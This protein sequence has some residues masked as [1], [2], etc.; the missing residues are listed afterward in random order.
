M[1]FTVRE[2]DR[3]AALAD[4]GSDGDDVQVREGV[5]K[6]V[7]CT[8]PDGRRRSVQMVGEVVVDEQVVDGHEAASF[9][10]G[11]TPH[12][13]QLARHALL[14]DPPQGRRRLWVK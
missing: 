6:P 8:S 10:A 3:D 5:A 12:A 1:P 2:D 4:S 14:L 11:R 13:D 7:S 9:V